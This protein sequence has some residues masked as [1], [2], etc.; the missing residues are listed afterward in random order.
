MFTQ[1][2]LTTEP[3]GPRNCASRDCL[4]FLATGLE[5]AQVGLKVHLGL[6]KILHDHLQSRGTHLEQ[7]SDGI[8]AATGHCHDLKTMASHPRLLQNMPVC[9]PCSSV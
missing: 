7:G 6:H 8:M 4:T 5:V 3:A 1:P 9:F 2:G